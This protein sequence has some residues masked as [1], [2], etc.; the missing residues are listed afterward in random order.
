MTK[1][2][3]NLSSQ[4]FKPYR[5]VTLGLLG[6]LLVLV[7]VSVWQGY[8]YRKYSALADGIREEEITLRA[9]DEALSTRIRDLNAKLGRA[10]VKVKL[11][12]V[13]FLNQMI[14]RK[15]FSWTKVFGTL[16]GLLPEG[17]HLTSL[18][19]SVADDGSILLSIVVR[20]R[21]PMEAYQFISLLE[22]SKFFDNVNVPVEQKKDSEQKKDPLPAGEIE[23]AVEMQYFASG[24]E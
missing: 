20:G 23:L 21:T 19:P 11:A 22:E 16:E 12:E 15:T 3:L 14:I 9:E 2:D 8:N 10:D 24:G 13:G 1:I 6:L 18:R 4:P 5:A 17:V 7:I